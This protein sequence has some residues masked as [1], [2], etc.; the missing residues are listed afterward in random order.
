MNSLEAMRQEIEFQVDDLR[1]YQLYLDT[2]ERPSHRERP[3]FLGCG[4]SFAAALAA[5]HIS[6]HQA[7]ALDPKE[8]ALNPAALD[9]RRLFVVSVSGRTSA[10]IEAARIGKRRGCG[11]TAITADPGSRLAEEADELIELRFRSAGALTSGTVSFTTSLLA[12]FHVLGVKPNLATLGTVL[13]SAKNWSRSFLPPI[14]ATTFFLGSGLG[15]AL[16]L[17]GAAKIFES[18]GAKSQAQHTEQFSHMELFSL[19]ASDVVVIIDLGSA[20]DP[21][22]NRLFSRLR[23]AGFKAFMLHSE[24]GEASA[25]S[26]ATAIHLQTVA[27]RAAKSRGWGSIAFV[28]DK[29]RL[30]LSN[31]MIY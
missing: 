21:T 13:R 10:N 16:A 24:K 14:R 1:R 7:I 11:V 4:D 15:Y 28:R 30:R 31:Y 8:A 29:R 17:Y 12:C 2:V 26:V 20:P 5:Q 19:T 23:E 18:L 25:A 27:Y 22:G 9:G 3:A 6:N